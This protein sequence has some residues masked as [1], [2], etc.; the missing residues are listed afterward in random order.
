MLK[1]RRRSGLRSGY[2]DCFPDASLL[3]DTENC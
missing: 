2:R 3:G 1:F